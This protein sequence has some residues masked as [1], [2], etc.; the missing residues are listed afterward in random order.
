MIKERSAISRDGSYRHI[1]TSPNAV[2]SKLLV[3]AQS[4]I[5]SSR[6]WLDKSHHLHGAKHDA[7]M[8]KNE[9]G[10]ALIQDDLPNIFSLKR[11]GSETF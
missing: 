6:G 9:L 5:F 1:P 2:P 8:R 11:Q 7:T 3:T 10:N 4:M